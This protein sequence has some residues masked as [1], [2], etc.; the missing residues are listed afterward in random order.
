MSLAHATCKRLHTDIT[1]LF[2]GAPGFGEDTKKCPG[3]IHNRNTT[4]TYME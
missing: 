2:R 1:E 4:G 3:C